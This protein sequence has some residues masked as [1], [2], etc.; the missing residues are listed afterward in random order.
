MLAY[1]VQWHMKQALSPMLFSDDELPQSKDTTDPVD[2]AEPSESAKKKKAWKQTD[3][4]IPLCSF[5]TLMT[6]LSAM[7]QVR[8]KVPGT[9]I[10]FEQYPIPTPLQEKAFKL[11]GV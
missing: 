1:Y 8:Y 6:M 2:K 5:D 4:D 9:D 11:L 10:I 7:T 3:D